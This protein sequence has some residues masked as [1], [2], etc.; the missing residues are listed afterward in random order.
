MDFEECEGCPTACIIQDATLFLSKKCPCQ[1]C[2]LKVI[3]YEGCKEYT[4]FMQYLKEAM[5]GSLK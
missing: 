5:F 3:C 1:E 4:I 2:L